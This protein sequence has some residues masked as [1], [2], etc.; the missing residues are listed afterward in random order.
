M[1]RRASTGT[2]G[3][4][5]FE[6]PSTMWRCE[7]LYSHALLTRAS[8]GSRKKL[9][10]EAPMVGLSAYGRARVEP[11]E[12]PYRMGRD[13]S[14]RDRKAALPRQLTFPNGEQG[15]EPCQ[16]YRQRPTV[17]RRRCF[18]ELGN[19]TRLCVTGAAGQPA[20]TSP[21]WGGVPVVVRDWESQSQGQGGQSG[22]MH[23]QCELSRSED[24]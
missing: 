24:V 14:L 23:A 4:T 8:P 10:F 9:P 5:V 21:V 18:C 13:L 17:A 7:S 11:L 1:V 2:R 22:S 12:V 16:V 6:A 20:A 3:T 19:H 15:K